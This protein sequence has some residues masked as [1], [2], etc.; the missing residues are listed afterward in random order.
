MASHH[1]QRKTTHAA[2][3]PQPLSTDF[4]AEWCAAYHLCSAL[5][6][7][8]C[9]SDIYREAETSC[10]LVQVP[11]GPCVGLLERQ[12]L[13]L[14][15]PPTSLLTSHSPLGEAQVFKFVGVEIRSIPTE[16][17]SVAP[18]QKKLVPQKSPKKRTHVP[19][20]CTSFHT[21]W[22]TM[23]TLEV[24]ETLAQ[25]QIHSANRPSGT[26]SEVLQLRHHLQNT[27]PDTREDEKRTMG[28]GL[29]FPL[30]SLERHSEAIWIPS[31]LNVP[32]NCKECSS[33]QGPTLFT[34]TALGFQLAV[35]SSV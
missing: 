8:G 30:V 14:R 6:I 25:I 9:R 23:S 3:L 7:L 10:G 21:S 28:V 24:Y 35:I 22:K 33:P 1:F 4:R 27:I 20:L 15:F 31:K 13:L 19:H 5:T 18:F 34:N 2:D 16:V 12:Q 32:K 29:G 26:W 11:S 17:A